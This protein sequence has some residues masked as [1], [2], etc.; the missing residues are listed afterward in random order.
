VQARLALAQAHAAA[1][2]LSGAIATLDQ[3][4]M[5]E[6]RVASTLAQ[7]QEQAGQLPGA[8]E[9]YTI[10]LAIEPGNRELKFRR[11]VVL[12]N[13]GEF[14]QAATF[15][16]DAQDQHPE[17]LRFPRLRARALFDSGAPARALS[18]LEPTA[19]A[20]PRDANTQFAMADLYT[21]A[22]RIDDAER[23]L[24]RLLDI[25]PGNAAVLNYLGYLLADNGRQLDEAISLVERALDMDPENPAYLDSL[26]WAHFRRGD[27]EE[28]EKY[29][30]PAA[31]RMP[32]NG[33][34]QDHLGDL[35]AGQ[36]RWQEAIAAWTRALDAGGEID[37]AAIE[38]KIGEARERGPR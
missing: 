11:V 33:V 36:G 20:N 26:G 14:A 30:R 38:K 10:A 23:T 4:V 3:V 15:A 5:D 12:F 21:D 29:L 6:P 7:Y 34:I 1:G 32:R 17:D 31:E 8:V 27:L 25:E 35:H 9:S 18:I 13:A 16:G 2:D 22:G 28:A 24:R 37:R 19:K